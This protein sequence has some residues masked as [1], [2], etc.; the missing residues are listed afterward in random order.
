[1]VR[2]NQ[3]WQHLQ[4]GLRILTVGPKVCGKTGYRLVTKAMTSHSCSKS[5]PVHHVWKIKD[6]GMEIQWPCQ[7]PVGQRKQGSRFQPDLSRQ[8]FS[9]VPEFWVGETDFEHFQNA[10]NTR[11]VVC[12]NCIIFIRESMQNGFSAI[13]LKSSSCSQ[14]ICIYALK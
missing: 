3:V 14:R 8:A 10:L 12:Y 5:V 4:C 11:C 6:S 1:M 2:L 13:P 9:D 7:C